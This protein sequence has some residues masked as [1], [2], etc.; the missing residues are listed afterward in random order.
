MHSGGLQLDL[1]SYAA[2]QRANQGITLA[3]KSAGDGWKEYAI[4][5][6]LGYLEKNQVLFVDDL[7]DAGL[8]E[9]KSPRALGAV[10]QEAARKGWIEEIKTPDGVA[11]RPSRR[12]NMQLKRVWKSLAYKK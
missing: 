1:A 11:A 9:P 2:R 6:L 5:F 8:R 7:W 4:S 12:S 10:I 3:E